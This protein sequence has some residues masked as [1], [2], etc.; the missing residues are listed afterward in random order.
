MGVCALAGSYRDEPVTI[1]TLPAN[2]I[3]GCTWVT[4][5]SLLLAAAVAVDVDVDEDIVEMIGLMIRMN[6]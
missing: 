6:E 1:A 4:F 5:T 3:T 2:V